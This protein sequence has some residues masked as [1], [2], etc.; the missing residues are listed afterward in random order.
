ML[1]SENKDLLK[2]RELLKQFNEPED[3]LEEG[4]FKATIDFFVE[5]VKIVVLAAAII[6]PIRYFLIQPFYV[7]GASMEPNFFDHEYLMINEIG[8][9][10]GDP[11]RGDVVVFK[12]PRDPKQFFIKRVVGL[13]GDTIEI[14]DNEVYLSE[15]SVG[16]P[17][18]FEEMYLATDTL[19]EP[20]NGDTEYIL[21]EGEYFLLGDNRDHSLDSRSFGPVDVNL[22][23]GKVWFRGWPV[24]RIEVFN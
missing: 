12:Y 18:L 23:V 13:P 22:I 10:F 16:E 4:W 5:T 15:G 3:E 20:K 2:D 11:E 17:V 1:D 21:S 8:Y 7:K 9:Q 24:D 6:L 19:T 14:R